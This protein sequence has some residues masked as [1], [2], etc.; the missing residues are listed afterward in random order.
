MRVFDRCCE[1]VESAG[2]RR[3]AQMGVLRCDH[4]DIEDFI[5]AKDDGDLTNFNMLGRRD[6]RVHARGRGRR[7][8]SSSCT[9]AEPGA[10]HKAP[11]RASAAT[12]CG[13]TARSRAREL[14][15]QI[16]RSTYDHAEPGVLFLDRINADNNLALLRDDRGDQP[17]RRTAA[18]RLRLLL[19]RLDQP[20]AASCASRS[21]AGARFDFDGVRRG[22][23][24]VA[25]AC[26]TTCSTPPSGR[27]RS[28]RDEARA[29]RRVGLG[30]TGLGDALIMLGLR[31]D[32]AGRARAWPR[33]SPRRCA[34][35]PTTRRHELAREKGA[36]PLFDADRY[37]AARQL[38]VA[39]ARGAEG[40]RSARTASATAPA[41][42][43]AHRH[44]QPRL[45]RQRL[46]RHRAAVLAGPTRARSAMPDGT[47]QGIRASRTTPGGCTGT[48]GRR[49]AAAAGTS[50]P[51]WRSPR[52]TTCA[53]VAAVAPFID[54]A[55]SKTVNVPEDYPYADFEDLYLDAWK[56]GPEGHHHL[57]AEQRARRGAHR[58]RPR[59]SA[60]TP[61]RSA[62]RQRRTAAS[63]SSGCPQPALASAALAGPARACPRGN[64]A[65]T[66]MVESP[67]GQFALFVGHVGGDGG[68]AHPVRGVGQRRRAAARP[69][70]GGQDAVDGHARAAT[71]AWLKHEARRA[72]AHRAATI[73]LRDADAARR[74]A[75]RR[76]GRGRGHSRAIVRWRCEQLGALARS[77]TAPHAGARRD[78]QREGAADRHRR[79]A[80]VDGRRLNP[81]RG[82]RLRADAE[83]NALP[84]GADR[85]PYSIW[86]VGR[87]PARA[88]RPVHA[89]S[90]STCA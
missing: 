75:Q 33:A 30:F 62:D 64:P 36:F 69:R 68:R 28:R 12:A 72:G 53:M 59:P 51:R 26:S 40:A 38:R 7:R 23:A 54:S 29:K 81:A 80:V 89:S 87:L 90:R 43:R 16:M 78:V 50:S 1:T 61:Q 10:A 48:A 24:H 4:P 44:D 55:I 27:C 74:R 3:G 25:C 63:R 47:H 56:C 57:P 14:W 9:S 86:L 88:R 8:L 19:P 77:S 35:R 71:A 37:L 67:V 79:H 58:R 34:T 21:R 46:E 13:S 6:R 82:R 17:V 20:H 70:R 39:P 84:D 66:Y 11:A 85:A 15:D 65:W 18:A 42:D 31:Y 76:A 5:H 83:G 22:R 73:A 32:T 60:R 49:R 45:R 52:A 41:V 2:A